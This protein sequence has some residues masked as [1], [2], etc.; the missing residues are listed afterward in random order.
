MLPTLR[1]VNAPRPPAST[2][3]SCRP[4]QLINHDAYR[5]FAN[6]I[7]IFAWMLNRAGIM[8]SLKVLIEQSLQCDDELEEIHA[9]A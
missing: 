1:S 5:T 2:C 3:L 7:R 9:Q 8:A 4:K 6:I